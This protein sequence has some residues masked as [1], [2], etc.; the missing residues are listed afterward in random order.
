M[1]TL[2]RIF[3]N[4]F[5]KTA[6]LNSPPIGAYQMFYTTPQSMEANHARSLFQL[7]SQMFSQTGKETQ[8]AS[9]TCIPRQLPQ[10]GFQNG[11]GSARNSG[12]WG[13]QFEGAQDFF[14][15]RGKI[16]YGDTLPAQLVPEIMKTRPAGLC[17]QF[18][19]K[20]LG[21]FPH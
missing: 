2:P 3:D 8:F 6:T 5:F 18:R 7:K 1:P 4:V 19:V 20:P 21:R 10:V 15:G 11:R 13:V 14:Q 16:A 12:G 17:D 9:F